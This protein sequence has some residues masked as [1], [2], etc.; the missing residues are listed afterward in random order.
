[1]RASILTID[2]IHIYI[3]ADGRVGL[4]EFAPF[5]VIHVGAGAEQLPEKV[6]LLTGLNLFHQILDKTF[7][8]TY[9][10]CY[11]E[12]KLVEQLKEG[13]RMVLPVRHGQVQIFESVDKLP[14]GEIKRAQLLGVSYVPLTDVKS[15]VGI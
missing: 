15:Q 7:L 1:M 12:L 5:D 13:G 4:E 10:N 9:Q 3:E 14:G 6:S 2:R 8:N 11:R